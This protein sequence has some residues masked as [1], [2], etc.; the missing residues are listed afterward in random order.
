SE[1]QSIRAALGLDK[2]KLLIVVVGGSLGSK[3]MNDIVARMLPM[4]SSNKAVAD[5]IQILHCVGKR[6]W[7]TFISN[8]PNLGQELSFKYV[9]VPFVPDL[10]CLLY[11][12][13]IV[14]CRGGAIT[15]SEAAMAGVTPIIVPWQGAANNEQMA[16]AMFFEQRG[17]AFVI[18][19]KKLDQQKLYAILADIAVEDNRRKEIQANCERLAEPNAAQMIG[20]AMLELGRRKMTLIKETPDF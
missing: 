2:N 20:S 6:H 12:S 16:N 9:P 1:G 5:K 7:D 15:L 17:A 14:I 11:A 8:S 13:D 4:L 10:H 3:L 19:E 18:E